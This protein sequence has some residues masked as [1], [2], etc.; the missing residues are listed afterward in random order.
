MNV[1]RAWV[2]L[3]WHIPVWG[4]RWTLDWENKRK[5]TVLPCGCRDSCNTI[6]FQK[7]RV[8]D[9][10]R[11]TWTCLYEISLRSR[12]VGWSELLRTFQS[13]F[14]RPTFVMHINHEEKVCGNNRDRSTSYGS[15]DQT[16]RFAYVTSLRVEGKRIY[17]VNQRHYWQRKWDIELQSTAAG[18]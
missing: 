13:C 18:K 12:S 1:V 2:G 15:R 4:W 3:T 9:L 11:S 14:S 7:I 10:L 17:Y 8:E 6:H 5:V 16:V